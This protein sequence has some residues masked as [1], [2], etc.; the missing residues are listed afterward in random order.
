VL[1]SSSLLL[2]KTDWHRKQSHD[3][4]N[5][6][7]ALLESFASC[8]PLPEIKP[9]LLFFLAKQYNAWHTVISQLERRAMTTSLEVSPPPA[10]I[11]IQEYLGQLYKLLGERDIWA[12][13]WRRR[14]ASDYTKSAL[15]LEQFGLWS[16]AQVRTH[17]S[18]LFLC[19]TIHI[20]ADLTNITGSMVLSINTC[21]SIGS[22]SNSSRSCGT[23]SMGRRMGSMCPSFESMGC[24]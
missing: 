12:A 20:M 4:P 16:R 23:T 13:L 9:E 21:Q 3:R 22:I 15:A 2:D 11:A 19:Q 24:T 18:S 17:H 1:I 10:A 7:Q 5:Q 6:V 8:Y 14:V